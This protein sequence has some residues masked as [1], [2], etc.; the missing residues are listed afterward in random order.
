MLKRSVPPERQ[1]TPP[2]W[3]SESLEASR[4]LVA[5]LFLLILVA[6]LGPT[7]FS[8]LSW[9][10]YWGDKLGVAE[11][12]FEYS[13]LIICFSAL[14]SMVMHEA[15]HFAVPGKDGYKNTSFAWGLVKAFKGKF[16]TPAAWVFVS[17]EQVANQYVLR[18]VLPFIVLGVIPLVAQFFVDG[19]VFLVLAS[20][21]IANI[22]GSRYD[23]TLAYAVL[24]RKATQVLDQPDGFDWR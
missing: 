8:S 24:R 20:I 9:D 17:G 3:N 12:P 13:M 6:C 19:K 7:F 1:P 22:I 5:G 11:L 18:C 2:G 15:L 23:L 10:R 16:R 4:W 21:A 14:L